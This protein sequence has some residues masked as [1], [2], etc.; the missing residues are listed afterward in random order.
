MFFFDSIWPKSMDSDH[1]KV[2][3][4][5]TGGWEQLK[6]FLVFQLKLYAEAIRD[7]FLS[8]LALLAFVTD[9]VFRLRGEDSLF[10]QLL[11]LGRKSERAINLFNQHDHEISGVSSIDGIVREVED[12]IRQR[13][14]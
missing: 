3:A 9:L 2:A 10:E 12:R 13:K 7:V 4:S 5:P 14:E 6:R 8:G 11:R 1:S